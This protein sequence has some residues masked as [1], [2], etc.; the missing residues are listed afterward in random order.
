MVHQFTDRSIPLIQ[1]L[2]GKEEIISHFFVSI[3]V[4]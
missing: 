2:A 1:V 4:L 3:W